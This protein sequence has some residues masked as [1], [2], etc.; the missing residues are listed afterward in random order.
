[1][2]AESEYLGLQRGVE[3]NAVHH[4]LPGAYAPGTQV[5]RIVHDLRGLPHARPGAYAP[6][7]QHRESPQDIIAQQYP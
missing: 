4:Q 2:P 3:F 7:T 5:D 1:M 6:S